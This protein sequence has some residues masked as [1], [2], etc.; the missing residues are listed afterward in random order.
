MTQL[1]KV[2][3]I[4][5]K[6]DKWFLII[7]IFM[8]IILSIIETVGITAIMPFITTASNPNIILENEYYKL[9]YD[10]FDFNSTMQFVIWFG[11]LL[12][13][14]YILRGIYT[15]FYTYTLNRFAFG[16]YHKFAFELLQGYTSISYK[17]FINKNSSTLTKTIVNEAM[18]ITYYLQNLLILFSEIFTI[19]F[20]YIILLFVDYKMT[21]ILTLIL[22]I[23]VLFIM[24]TISKKIKK[25]GLRRSE[26]QD[27]F[28]RILGKAFGN[29][30][31]TKLRG[32]EATILR[33]FSNKSE[34]FSKTNVLNSTLQVMPRIILEVIGFGML[35]SIVMYVLVTTKDATQ[36][37]P[38]VSIYALALYRMLPALTKILNSYNQ[39]MYLSTALDIVYDDLVVPV[40]TEGNTQLNF[41]EKIEARNICF[42]YDDEND[43]L[44]NLN[45]T[46][47]KGEKVAFIGAS[48][49]GK[50]TLVDVLIGI[51]KPRLGEV[52]IDGMILTPDNIRS[53]RK[54]VGYIPQS[55]YLFDGTVS[56]NISFGDKLDQSKVID[57]LKKANI[58]DYL[59]QQAEGIETKV[60]EGGI[61]LSGGQ[62]QRIGIARALY[63]EPDIL[64]LDEATS[65]L[66]IDTEE[67]IMKE[68][69]KLSSD[70]TL[71]IIAHRLSTIEGCER[72]I[73]LEKLD[74]EN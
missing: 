70:K 64:V 2:K 24:K 73:D 23:K 19:S 66:D 40:D 52:L 14:F 36:I 9:I 41:N 32:N 47:N 7:L 10:F 15:I 63:N 20:L 46:I 30:K 6:K 26:F 1:N 18:N 42:S 21:L 62:K 37:I 67:K 72:V 57:A 5:S 58:Y 33:E 11:A 43:I 45:L 68:I 74:R 28:Y 25:E 39:M 35:I 3:A 71:L 56:E 51:Y 48:G 22:V 27:G 55:I 4:I 31:F 13:V 53:W 59:E 65:A 60:G 69:Y 54:K 16:R 44:K 50:S 17:E 12:I 49:S 34:G 61:K 38:I 8:S 29:F